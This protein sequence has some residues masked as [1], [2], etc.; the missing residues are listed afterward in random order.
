MQRPG[1]SLTPV[2]RR[3]LGLHHVAGDFLQ[4]SC[5]PTEE[6][7]VNPGCFLVQRRSSWATSLMRLGFTPKRPPTSSMLVPNSCRSFHST[8]VVNEPETGGATLL[9]PHDMIQRK[10]PSLGSLGMA[11]PQGA[12]LHRL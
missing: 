4:Y 12:G 5:F 10:R 1:E 6:R 7:A 9:L 2:C 11:I 3:A 8:S